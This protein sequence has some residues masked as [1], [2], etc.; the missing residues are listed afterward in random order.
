MY[1]PRKL[2]DVSTDAS[3][4]KAPALG[5]TFEPR[6]APAANGRE[7]DIDLC[8]SLHEDRPPSNESYPEVSNG[9]LAIE[10]EQL[11]FARVDS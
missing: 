9:P 3:D 6:A 7:H 5:G 2:I 8:R 11:E 10:A 4:H 1:H